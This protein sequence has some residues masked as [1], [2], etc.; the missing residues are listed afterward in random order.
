MAGPVVA[1]GGGQVA[2]GERVVV[3]NALGL[4]PVPGAIIAN[5]KA[6]ARSTATDLAKQCI[7][8]RAG[9]HAARHTQARGHLART[10]ESKASPVLH[11]VSLPGARCLR[12]VKPP[13]SVGCGFGL[14]GDVA[15]KLLGACGRVDDG[16]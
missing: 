4:L 1:K 12:Q 9:K 11:L 13:R 14:L 16:T 2:T 5:I 8:C 3:G 15:V 6:Q 10:S 7:Q